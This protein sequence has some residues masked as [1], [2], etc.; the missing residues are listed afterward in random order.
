MLLIASGVLIAFLT[1]K[2]QDK[3]LLTLYMPANCSTC[4][5]YAEY[6]KGHGFRVKVDSAESLA[7][8]RSRY[9]IPAVF[10]APHVAVVD[11]MFI[12]GHVP[13]SN[14]R[15]LLDARNRGRAKGILV[16]GTPKGA[17]GLSSAFPEPYTV[18]LVRGGG[19]LQ[20][21]QN[22]NHGYH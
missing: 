4:E 6:L 21:I 2:E 13:A 22:Y 1:P 8:I 5:K 20:P 17:P 10:R 9:H 19:L 15:Q 11:D 7:E 16:P 18:Y 12:E 14:I 3:P